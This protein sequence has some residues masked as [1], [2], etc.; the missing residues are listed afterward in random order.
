M[1]SA[2]QPKDVAQAFEIEKSKLEEVMKD[3]KNNLQK[4][5]DS[6]DQIT[7]MALTELRN[8]GPHQARFYRSHSWSGNFMTRIPEFINSG[9]GATIVHKGSKAAVIYGLLPENPRSAAWLLAWSKPDDSTKPIRV[10]VKGGT[11][12]ALVQN[13]N[14]NEV[15]KELDQSGEISQDMDPESGAML[16]GRIQND[17]D[18]VALVGTTLNL[19]NPFP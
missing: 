16:V 1:A 13:V 4:N 7:A 8:G 18:K 11:R 5:I 14:W 6:S 3:A 10:Y 19:F 12:D 17:S 2:Q 9:D 15:E